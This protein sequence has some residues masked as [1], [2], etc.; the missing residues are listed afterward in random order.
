MVRDPAGERPESL[1]GMESDKLV[2]ELDD[3]QL[4][5]LKAEFEPGE[6]VL[7]ADRA[8]PPPAP[9]I[10][11]FPAFFAAVLCAPVVSR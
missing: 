8:G 1:A 3:E 7:W 4:A 10:G 9:T 6:R 2:G 5:A 11:A